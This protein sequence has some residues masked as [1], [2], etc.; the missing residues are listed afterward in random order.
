MKATVRN[1]QRVMKF[2]IDSHE[3]NMRGGEFDDETNLI[4]AVKTV[5]DSLQDEP[6]FCCSN[7][8]GGFNRDE[9]VFDEDNENDFCKD[10]AK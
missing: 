9:M 1:V 8:G 5:I 4:D 7:C 10:C 3:D 2:I 6:E